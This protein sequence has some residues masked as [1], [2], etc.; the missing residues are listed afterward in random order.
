MATKTG[1]FAIIEQ[2]L[3]DGVRY[4]FGNPG[5]VEQGF[6]DALGAYPDFTYILA[7]QETI[8]VA[9]ADGHARATKTPAVVQL[10]S[11]VGLGNGV[12]M[13]YQAMRGHAPLVVIAGEAGLRYDAMDA[14]MAADLVGMARPVTKWA[15]RVVHPG[16]LLRVLRRAI[17]LAATPPMGP[18]FVAL[19]ADVLD[20]PN[21]EPV[22][23]TPRL[24][25]AGVPAA[26]HVEEAAAVLAEAQRPLI[27]MG[28]G[29]AFARAQAE[30]TRV[31]ELLGAEVWGADT[32]EVNMSFSHPLFKGALGH[33]F[34]G[35]SSAVSTRA[36]AVLIVGTYVF[37]EVYP[38]LEGVFASGAK[39]VHVDLNAYEV[40][41][42][43]PVHLGLVSDPKL[44]LGALAEAL[45]GRLS[46][47]QRRAAKDRLEASGA[48][49]QAAL[50]AQLAHD[51][52]VREAVPMHAGPFMEALARQA[53]PDVVVFDEALTV[54]PDV[55]R[56]LVPT[57]PDHFFQT[58]GGS[59]GVGIPG[60]LGIKLARPEK[61]VIGF[62]GDGGSMYTI[63]A[64]WTAAHHN[65]GAKFVIC[66]NQ[67][68]MLL[69]LNLLQYWDEQVGV[70]AHEFPRSFDLDQPGI[71]FAALSRSMGVP[72]VRVERPEQIEGAVRQMLAHDGPFL[73]D[74]LLSNAVPGT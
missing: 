57:L 21:E 20:A 55:T 4:M 42:N 74:L 36:D 26:A 58:R 16:S 22:V 59:L 39:V 30:L 9:M 65:I 63:Q 51:R 1:R 67:S 33:M 68:Y 47:E 10:H 53:P 40:A 34:G 69:K 17:K 48:A 28:D 61:T 8:A 6:L 43:F 45:E 37:P 38:Q 41:K 27:V 70:P 73:V 5:T 15:T 29:I 66:N 14:Q 11:G 19:P 44:T 32:S 46:E 50:E 18:V 54:S 72:G 49:K 25:T 52:A 23:P 13:L 31:A 71:D 24:T 62:T 7:L 35:V 3:A 64:L 60:A 12:G 56:Y 2:F